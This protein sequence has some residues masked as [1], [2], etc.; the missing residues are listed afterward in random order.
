M[1]DACSLIYGVPA[2]IEVKACT[3]WQAETGKPAAI[4]VY[5]FQF[6]CWNSNLQCDGVSGGG[7]A[8]FGTW[9]DHEGG[10]L[11]NRI[12]ALLKGTPESFLT[13]PSIWRHSDKT[14]VCEPGSRLS[15]DTQ[16]AGTLMLISQTPN[17]EKFLLLKSHTVHGIHY[18]SLNS[19]RQEC[20][21]SRS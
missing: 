5:V 13:L 11:V 21:T 10:A 20:P 17:P 16:Y 14:A 7:G 9:L 2:L 6:I 4:N 19:L 12:G 1:S 8:V 15:P 3:S 18:S